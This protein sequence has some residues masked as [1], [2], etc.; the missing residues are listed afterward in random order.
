MVGGGKSILGKLRERLGL[1]KW[2]EPSVE[3]LQDLDTKTCLFS[4]PLL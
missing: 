3:L 2:F 4:H 1:K